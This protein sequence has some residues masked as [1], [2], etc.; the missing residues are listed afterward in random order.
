M[1]LKELRKYLLNISEAELDQPVLVHALGE[2]F[3]VEI[4]VTW[5]SK[6]VFIA[7]FDHGGDDGI[8]VDAS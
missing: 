7:T 2:E 4:A 1:L 3:E 8:E 5:N 6:N